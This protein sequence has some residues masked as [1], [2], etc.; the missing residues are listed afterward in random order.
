MP[1]NKRHVKT[2]TVQYMPDDVLGDDTH[3]SVHRTGKPTW[4][5]ERETPARMCGGTLPPLNL[6]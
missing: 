3:I 6:F 4:T 1:F 5:T 2:Y